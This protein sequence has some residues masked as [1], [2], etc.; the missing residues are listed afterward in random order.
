MLKASE[1]FGERGIHCIVDGQFGSTGKGALA[2]F[3]ADTALSA[4]F[5]NW[6][7]VF[8][9]AGPNSGHTFYH[10][11]E[12]HV[13]KQLPSFAVYMALCGNPIPVYLTGGAIIDPEILVAEAYKYSDVPIFVHPNAAVIGQEDKATEH[14]GTVAA[15]AGTR[16]G[17]GAALARKVLRDPT[18]VFSA[19]WHDTH[20][21]A[22]V[23]IGWHDQ[24][25]YDVYDQ[26]FFMEVSQGYS[27]GINSPFY[28]KVTSREC[29]V[30][31]GLA[32][33]GIAP[34]S[35]QRVY[36]ALRTYPIRVGNVDGF[37]SGGYYADQNETSWEELSQQPELTTVTQRVRRVFTFSEQQALASIMAN[38]PDYVFL[39]F[40][41]YLDSKGE[42]EIME[43]MDYV[44]DNSIKFF[45]ILQGYGPKVEDVKW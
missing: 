2:A 25:D 30:A 22:N 27:L 10:N 15:V 42:R 14:S 31:Q 37:D 24:V 6:G 36:L 29:T 12:K 20:F 40:M 35:L 28:P 45:H 39:N 1:L 8:S 5:D 44:R 26:P 43:K 38:Q 4:G 34:Q 11:G 19:H 23:N 18:V 16:S 41:N 32:D 17:T 3:L 13:L 9:N 21:P 33:A 7:G